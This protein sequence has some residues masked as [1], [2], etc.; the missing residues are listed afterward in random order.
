MPVCSLGHGVHS[1]ANAVRGSSEGVSCT[2]RSWWGALLRVTEQSA[3]KAALKAKA[4]LRS[5]GNRTYV[6]QSFPK[7]P[8]SNASEFVGDSSDA[9]S[10]TSLTRGDV[11]A[12][13]EKS[14]YEEKVQQ[15]WNKPHDGY[16]AFAEF[17]DCQEYDL[18]LALDKDGAVSYSIVPTLENGE[19]ED[20]GAQSYALFLEA[21]A[22]ILREFC[23]VAA[24]RQS[25]QMPLHSDV[26]KTFRARRAF[27]LLCLNRTNCFLKLPRGTTYGIYSIFSTAR[28][29][30]GAKLSADDGK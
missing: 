7:I 19:R 25:T 17:N 6:K 8:G 11:K 29:L 3:Y 16:D 1:A 13:V 2:C 18:P 24:S 4:L 27:S 21:K 22:P 9:S 5:G 15:F 23:L 20:H 10:S 30:S 26:H 12:D 28:I 14:D